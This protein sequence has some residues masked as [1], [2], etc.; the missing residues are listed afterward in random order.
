VTV[1]LAER[2]CVPCEGGT[3]PLTA[4]EI[5]PLQAQ[6]EGWEVEDGKRLTKTFAFPDFVKAVDFVNAITPVAEA[7][8]HHPDLTVTWG[9]VGVQ[10]WTHAVGGLSENDFILAAK[11]DQL[12]RP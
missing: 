11:I 12:P 9:K 2:R 1:R 3:P 6:L 10:L 7:E 8:G 4:E 5:G